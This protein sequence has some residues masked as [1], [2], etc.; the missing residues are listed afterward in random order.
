MSQPDALAQLA[1]QMVRCSTPVHHAMETSP[2]PNCWQ[3]SGKVPL[4]PGLRV[5]CEWR[6]VPHTMCNQ[7]NG[8]PGYTLVSED[9]AE[10]V[11]AVWVLEGGGELAAHKGKGDT[12][13]RVRLSPT[14]LDYVEWGETVGEALFAALEQA[15]GLEVQ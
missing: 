2:C 1:A 4:I 10:Q 7:A 6:G 5:P 15:L 12:W 8:C 3:N 14:Q 9:T 11:I 13:V